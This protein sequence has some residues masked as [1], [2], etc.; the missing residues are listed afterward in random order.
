M[1]DIYIPAGPAD[2]IDQMVVVQ[3]LAANAPDATSRTLYSQRLSQMETLAAELLPPHA[4][5]ST[6]GV[7]AARTDLLQLEADMRDCEARSDFGVSFIALTRAYLAAR[8][9]LLERKRAFDAAVG[10]A[11][12]PNCDTVGK[13][14]RHA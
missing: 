2:L 13:R 1:P 9:T 3:T 4:H 11:L 7:T 5:R 8:A 6:A 14:D 12:S 10:P